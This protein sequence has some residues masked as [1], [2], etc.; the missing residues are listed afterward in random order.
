VT[1]ALGGGDDS[2]KVKNVDPDAVPLGA[3]ELDRRPGP[4]LLA[5][6]G[7]GNGRTA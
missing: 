1:L 6:Q 3:V 4:E 5:V 7:D 2:A